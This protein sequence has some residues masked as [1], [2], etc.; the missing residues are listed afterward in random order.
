[1]IE[2]NTTTTTRQQAVSMLIVNKLGFILGT[3]RRDNHGVFGLAGGKVEIGE[4]VI[5]AAKRELAEE[6]LIDFKN[7]TFNLIHVRQGDQIEDNTFHV[8]VSKSFT[9]NLRDASKKLLEKGEGIVKWVTWTEL[10]EGPFG[11]YNR[12]ISGIWNHIQS[13]DVGTSYVNPR[14]KELLVVENDL[15]SHYVVRVNSVNDILLLK[16]GSLL[17]LDLIKREDFKP[18]PMREEIDRMALAAVGAHRNANHYYQ[19]N[20]IHVHYVEHLADAVDVFHEFKHLIPKSEQNYVEAGLWFHDAPE[21]ARLTFNDVKKLSNESV[22]WL[23]HAL[24]T[25]KGY[26]RA[27][28]APKEYYD[29]I[30]K[31]PHGVFAKL[32]D[33]IANVRC[34]IISG[35]GVDMYKKELAKFRGHLD[36][37]ARLNP[38][39]DL[40]EDYLNNF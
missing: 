8:P 30:K 7:H 27:T 5:D 36:V 11:S 33:R 18:D 12:S 10:F 16:R 34:G 35:K 22:A 15:G 4:H 39:W 24:T 9:P 6:T 19:L 23:A 21:D 31:V 3:S 28:R 20:P 40:L 38:M 14:T 37:D 29:E 26:N 2:F 1:M 13:L 25:H 17:A 32:C